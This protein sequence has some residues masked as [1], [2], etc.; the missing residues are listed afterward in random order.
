VATALTSAGIPA[1][2]ITVETA[3]ARGAGG[4]DVPRA[5]VYLEN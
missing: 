4:R 1:K 2:N 5:E 3:P